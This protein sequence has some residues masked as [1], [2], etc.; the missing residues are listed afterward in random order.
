MLYTTHFAKANSGATR[1]SDTHFERWEPLSLLPF[2]QMHVYAYIGLVIPYVMMF[3]ETKLNPRWACGNGHVRNI[4]L[5]WFFP[6]DQYF[7]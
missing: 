3:P 1:I 7:V 2:Y 6:L 4:G 5:G